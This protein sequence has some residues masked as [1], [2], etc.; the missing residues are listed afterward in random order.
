MDNLSFIAELKPREKLVINRE[1]FLGMAQA[2]LILRLRKKLKENEE[3]RLIMGIPTIMPK[4][5]RRV[6][7]VEL[8]MSKLGADPKFAMTSVVAL[9]IGMVGLYFV[10]HCR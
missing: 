9:I 4:K 5:S 7:I 2:F 6:K 3:I 1:D 10:S 8:I